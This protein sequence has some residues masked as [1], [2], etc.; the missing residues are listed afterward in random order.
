MIKK[1]RRICIWLVIGIGGFVPFLSLYAELVQESQ[2]LDFIDEMVEEHGFKQ[3]TLVDLFREVKIQQSI[4]TRIS[5]PAESMTW[6]QYRPIFITD[7]RVK[8][9]AAF[10][11]EHR[12]AFERAAK[13]YG[14]A[15]TLVAAVMGVETY[16]GRIQ[17]QDSVL[18][19]LATLAFRYPPRAGFFRDEL[20]NFLVL[21]CEERVKP[22]DLD[23]SCSA[24]R[25]HNS[26]ISPGL[27]ITD[28]KGSYAGAMGYGQFIPSSFRNFAID[29]D[30]DQS[31]DIWHNPVDAIGS[32][33]NYFAEHGWKGDGKVVEQVALN[34][35]SAQADK[36]ANSGLELTRT[37]AE[38]K[39]LGV[40]ETSGSGTALAAL[41]RMEGKNGT[42]YWL[43]YHDFYVITRYNRSSMYALAVWQL[44]ELIGQALD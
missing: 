23:D 10:L 34:A 42:E 18:N 11:R 9:G 14:V 26:A 24:T 37:V 4:I 13:D 1:K 3:A 5:R 30:G 2:V 40:I 36:F 16:Y 41:F 35:E 27:K 43:G 25:I 33:A 8:A 12:V 39:K 32:V 17:G 44:S 31:R 20:K 38:W 19:S 28:L 21:A 7:K 29:Y 15:P 6:R 22:F